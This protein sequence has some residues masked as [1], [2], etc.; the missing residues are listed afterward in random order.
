MDNAEGNITT[1]IQDRILLMGI[2]RPAKL[3]GFTPHMMDQLVDAYTLLDD[4]DDLWVGVLFAH[5]DHFTA[6]LD[7]PKFSER[8]KNNERGRGKGKTDPTSLGKRCKKPI[9][10]AVKGITFTLGIEL[11]LAGDIVI[12]ADNCR[13]SQ[14]EPLRG[15]HATGGAT[16]RFV[17]R[18]GWGNAM[19]HLLTSDEFDSEEAHRI[20]LVQEIVPAGEETNRAIEIAHIICEGAPLAVQAT[21]ASSL[22]YATQ[23]ESACIAAF[24]PKQAELAASEDAIEGI[25]SFKERRKGNFSGK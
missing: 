17:E 19:Y 11:M 5:G 4:N 14:L 6:G 24:G 3:N 20:G 13:F 18:G 7:L 15:I 25:A 2:N 21:K 22:I 8:M 1:E 12:A 23:G 9:I 10:S 16:I